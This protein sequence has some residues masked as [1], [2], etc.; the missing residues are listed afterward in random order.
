MRRGKE[1][2]FRFDRTALYGTVKLFDTK[3]R[4]GAKEGERECV[5]RFI[6]QRR[7]KRTRAAL[8][9][10]ATDTLAHTRDNVWPGTR[11]MMTTTYDIPK[12]F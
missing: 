1:Q 10:P 2:G 9:M 12:R 5:H 8:Q 4:S 3:E 11:S 6:Q 7:G